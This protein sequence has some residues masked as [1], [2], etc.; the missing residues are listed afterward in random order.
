MSDLG[1]VLPRSNPQASFDRLTALF[2]EKDVQASAFV[3]P[4]ELI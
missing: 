2:S 3:D 1:E 4:L